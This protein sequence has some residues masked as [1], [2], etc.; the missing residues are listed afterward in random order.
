MRFRCTLILIPAAL[1]AV[2]AAGCISGNQKV[3]LK[4]QLSP[5]AEQMTR[6]STSQSGP[7]ADIDSRTLQSTSVTEFMARPRTAESELPSEWLRLTLDEAISLSLQNTTVLRSLNANVTRSPQTVATS[8]DPAIQS[9][10]P[11]FGVQAALAQFDSNLTAALNHSNNDDVFNN[12]ILGGGA[13]EVVQD[14]TQA[15][16]GVNRTAWSGTQFAVD[17]NVTY[18]NN[19]NVSSTFPSSYSTFWQAQVRQPLLQGRGYAFNRIAGPN[20]RTGFLGTSG[21]LVSR[22]NSDI[23]VDEFEKGVISHIDEVINAYWDLYFSIRNFEA[24]KSARNSSLETWNSVKARFDNDLPGGEADAEAQ[25]R[26]QYFQFEERMFAALNGNT[27]SGSV[28][29]YQAEADLRRLIGMPQSDERLVWPQD[30][31]SPVETVFDWGALSS[32]AIVSRVEVR[33]Q[34]RR[35]RQRELE[36][37]AS[38]NFL[39]PRLDAVATFRNNGFGDQLTGDGPTRFVS[40]YEDL[41]SGDHNEW[42]FGVQ[43]DMPVGFRQANAGVRN[44]QL[45]LMRERAVLSETRQ[46]ILHELGSSL[47]Q[48][49]QSWKSAQLNFNRMKATEDAWESRLAAYEAGNVS[50]DRLLEAVQRRA[51]ASS[52]FER[53]QA[54]FQIAN[55]AI[56]RDSGS[57][58]QEFGIVVDHAGASCDS[59]VRVSS[60]GFVVPQ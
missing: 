43:L 21:F 44:S 15:T 55:A 10:D 3:V 33:Q 34:A 22:I 14:L 23:S 52:E 59:P 38:K 57:L 46:Q 1:L 42:E 37:L 18:D 45:E 50:V 19:D 39:L 29:V 41:V 31:P 54:N 12:S 16:F 9:S 49:S 26:E 13:T 2:A 53:A 56:K 20:A 27:R 30:E 60:A 32:N 25:A 47:R 51:D 48:T 58:L 36:L 11:N 24:I 4:Q 35:V 8:L 40:A 17:A 6:A 5:L 28:G 7:I